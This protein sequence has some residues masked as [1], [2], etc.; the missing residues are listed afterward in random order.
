[1]SEGGED[2]AGPQL[3]VPQRRALGD[4]PG[5]GEG[6]QHVD[7]GEEVPKLTGRRGIQVWVPIAPGPGFDE[8]RAWVERVSR[9]VGAVVPDLVS[10]RR[11]VRERG[12]QARLDY[13]QNATNSETFG[14]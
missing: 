7:R 9:T 2:V 4:R 6:G 13:P 8:T 11:E 14:R 12:G 1:V 5:G 10:W 3:S